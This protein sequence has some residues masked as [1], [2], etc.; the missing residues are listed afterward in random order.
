MTLTMLNWL[1]ELGRAEIDLFPLELSEG[2]IL[3]GP[4][5]DK[6]GK[7]ICSSKS[8]N[9]SWNAVVWKTFK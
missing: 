2:T 1:K 6:M 7:I 4:Q 5:I 8:E 3:E 9:E